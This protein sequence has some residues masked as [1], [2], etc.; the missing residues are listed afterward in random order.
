[1]KGC[2]IRAAKSL[3]ATHKKNVIIAHV[4]NDI[5]V[6]GA[7]FTRAINAQWDRPELWYRT[8]HRNWRNGIGICFGLGMTQVVPTDDNA[9]GVHVSNMIG[10]H[11]ICG[12]HNPCPI[13]YKALAVCLTRLNEATQMLNA[14][15][16]MPRI[17]CGLAGGKWEM[18]EPLIQ[19]NLKEVD[20]RVFTL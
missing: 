17:G 20:V 11:G 6:W 16:V 19:E 3:A 4:C 10:Q 13:R 8:W 9:W 5:G 15:V 7:G 12:Y 1:M 2:A 14:S 18:V